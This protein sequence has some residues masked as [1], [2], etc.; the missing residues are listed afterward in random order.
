MA[1]YALLRGRG[2]GFTPEKE[3][4]LEVDHYL[5]GRNHSIE[6]VPAVKQRETRWGTIFWQSV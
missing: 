4:R 2:L 1:V 5:N 6:R 3:K